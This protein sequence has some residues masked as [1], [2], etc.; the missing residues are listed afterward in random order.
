MMQNRWLF[1]GRRNAAIQNR[2]RNYITDSAECRY[3]DA[4]YGKYIHTLDGSDSVNSCASCHKQEH[5][6]WFWNFGFVWKKGPVSRFDPLP[7]WRRI[8]F[9]RRDDVTGIDKSLSAI[10][11]NRLFWHQFQYGGPVFNFFAEFI[12]EAKST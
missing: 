6:Q 1:Y 12:R 8:E 11:A 10:A 5:R 7:L 4:A 9:Q 2:Q 3:V